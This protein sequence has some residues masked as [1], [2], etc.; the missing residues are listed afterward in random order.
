MSEGTFQILL[1]LNGP[2]AIGHCVLGYRKTERLDSLLLDIKNLGPEQW[3]SLGNGIITA[4][5]SL[6]YYCIMECYELNC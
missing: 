2:K 4:V 3:G 6:L 1:E 5:F